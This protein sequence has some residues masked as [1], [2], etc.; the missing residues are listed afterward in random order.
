MASTHLRRFA[1]EAKA[2]PKL[3]G[4]NADA[5]G[6]RP[7]CS[8]TRARE[9]R[10]A[11]NRMPVLSAFPIFDILLPKSKVDSRIFDRR[12]TSITQIR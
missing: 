10:A 4:N 3:V 11:Q 9:A 12:F 5:A 7:L 6:L 8:A 2:A 1:D